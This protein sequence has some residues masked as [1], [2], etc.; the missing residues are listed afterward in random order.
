MDDI[1]KRALG[2]SRE[3]K[4]I[5]FKR[6]F[7]GSAPGAWCELI[8][9][10]V[11]LA[12]SGGGIVVFGLDS[13][14]A[15]SGESIAEIASLDPADVLNKLVKYIGV[16]NFEIETFGLKK[17]GQK[18]YAFAIS[19]TSIPHVFEQP[20]TY[21][22]G[23]GKQKSAFGLGTVYFRHGAKSEPGTS[24]DLRSSM[25]RALSGIR[26]SW[27]KG[28]RQVVQAPQ[29]AEIVT[30]QRTA[31]QI[32]PITNS[33]RA[34][35]DPL[36]TPVALTRDLS[37][38]T[39]TI[40]Y[41]EIAEG[42]FEEINNVIDANKAL[43]KGQ[44]KFFLGPAIYYRIYA[45]RQH[46]LQQK[47][48]H[49]LLLHAAVVDFYAP[50]L[51]WMTVMPDDSI[52]NSFVEL[53]RNP[54]SPQIHALVRLA[55]VLGDDFSEWL[56]AKMNKRWAAHPQPPTFY[57]TFRSLVKDL[58]SMDYRLRSSRF[59]TKSRIELPG[60]EHVDV[61]DLLDNPPQAAALLSRV[62]MMIFEGKLTTAGRSVARNLDYL[63]Y[64]PIVRERGKTISAA[65]VS[66][67]GDEQIGELTEAPGAQETGVM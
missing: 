37:R 40:Y 29:G 56:L 49:E 6:G 10:I 53:Y 55:T 52:A 20:G 66:K 9:D 62:C 35:G 31:R 54:V 44:K 26:K 25:D 46:V 16:P 47:D 24:D 43:A 58:H 64:G 36:A 65:I 4:R 23:G 67:V 3:S 14:G 61:A 22:I 8:K 12:N 11:A 21:D 57:W 28:V 39:G 13:A 2:A 42:I 5:E 15:P 60:E 48:T 38:A 45:E 59:S 50:A 33:V 34:V 30:I 1:V 18:L 41:E 63:A 27:I 51:F 32:S 19:G 17:R 7:E